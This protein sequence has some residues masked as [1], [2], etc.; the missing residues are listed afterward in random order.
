MTER[1]Y[2]GLRRGLFMTAGLLLTVLLVQFAFSALILPRLQLKRILLESTLD[3]SDRALLVMGGLTG[4]ESYLSIDE[5]EIRTRYESSPLVRKAYVE[6]QFPG[7]LKIVLYGRSP[8]GLTFSEG[9][10]TPDV[11]DEYGV[12]YQSPVPYL[13]LPVLSGLEQAGIPETLVPF[14]KDLRILQQEEPL[15]YGQISEI[16][17]TRQEGALYELMLYTNAYR[18]PVLLSSGLNREVMKK[19]LLVLDSLKSGN[20]MNNLEYADF[21]TDQVVLK[22]REVR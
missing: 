11:F 13:N 20:Q 8:L 15:L 18:L 21:R 2:T 10:G 19:I 9:Q 3:L 6:K 5:T 7:T 22:T 4:E 14:L 16:N 1:L 12:V 17:L